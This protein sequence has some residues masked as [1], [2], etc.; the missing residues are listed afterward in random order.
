MRLDD[1][2]QHY[3]NLLFKHWCYINLL[4]TSHE[5][6]GQYLSYHGNNFERIGAISVVQCFRTQAGILLDP[7]AFFVSTSL[8]S[9][10]ISTVKIKIWVLLDRVTGTLTHITHTNF[11]L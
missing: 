5:E 6:Y 9:S 4:L 1:S 11:P 8:T 10:W 3:H 2:L 7:D